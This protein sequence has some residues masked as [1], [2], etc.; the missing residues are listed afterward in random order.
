[1]KLPAVEQKRHKKER[2]RRR[3]KRSRKKWRAHKFNTFAAQLKRQNAKTNKKKNSLSVPQESQSKSKWSGEWERARAVRI[4]KKCQKA[5]KNKSTQPQ[6]GKKQTKKEKNISIV[7]YLYVR[8]TT[9]Y[10]SPP[11]WIL[12]VMSV[13]PFILHQCTNMDTY[14]TRT[15]IRIVLTRIK[16]KRMSKSLT[17]LGTLDD[18]LD[19]LADRIN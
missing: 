1:M 9:T 15:Y 18:M 7:T 6:V 17:T 4:R 11:L 13:R 12:W 16:Q 14:Y 5:K 10:V 8:W 3:I 19:I 2:T